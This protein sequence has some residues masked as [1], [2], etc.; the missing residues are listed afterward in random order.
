[1]TA[2]APKMITD[3]TAAVSMFVDFFK[4]YSFFSFVALADMVL[5]SIKTAMEKNPQR[6]NLSRVTD[7]FFVG[8]VIR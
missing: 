3:L 8:V 1:M 4:P 7:V 5:A 2:I 6:S